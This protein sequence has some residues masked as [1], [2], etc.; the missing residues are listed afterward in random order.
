MS[1]PLCFLISCTHSSVL[2][3]SGITDKHWKQPSIQSYLHCWNISIIF[4]LLFAVGTSSTDN[5]YKSLWNQRP[6]AKFAN[7]QIRETYPVNLL[8]LHLH[9]SIRFLT[10]SLLLFNFK[11][12]GNC[13]EHTIRWCCIL[14]CKDILFQSIVKTKGQ[15]KSTEKKTLWL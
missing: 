14:L 6:M 10:A 11:A 4:P 15:L 2:K 13:S 7:P 1:F 3:G 8:L 9:K 12:I 5:L